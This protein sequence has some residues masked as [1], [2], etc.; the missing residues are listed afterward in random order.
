MN[1]QVVA[2]YY[3][4]DQ[5]VRTFGSTKDSIAKMNDAEVMTFALISALYYKADYRCTRFV[6][7]SLRYFSTILSHSRS[8]Y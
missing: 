3:I 1:E 4:C 7:M 2:I 8:I 6:A 5:V